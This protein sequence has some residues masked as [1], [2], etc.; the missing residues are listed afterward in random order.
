MNITNTRVMHS[1]PADIKAKRLEVAKQMGAH[2]TLLADGSEPRA[3]AQKVKQ[4][5]GCMPEVSLECSGVESALAT[6]IYVRHSGYI[7]R[8]FFHEC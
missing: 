3:F 7:S 5:M 6:A 1:L 2:H 8:K 4:T